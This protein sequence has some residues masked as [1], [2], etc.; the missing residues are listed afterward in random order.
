MNSI[1]L[2]PLTVSPITLTGIE[3]KIVYF[4]I[5]KHQVN[6]LLFFFGGPHP[7]RSIP[8]GSHQCRA[9]PQL[10]PTAIPCG[11]HQCR[12]SPQLPPTATWHQIKLRSPPTIPFLWYLSPRTLCALIRQ[13]PSQILYR[14]RERA[15]FCK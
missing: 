10:P 4:I 14:E 11:S 13:N 8:C 12:P 15:F 6:N 2:S 7:A 3:R 1:Q 9:S 5:I